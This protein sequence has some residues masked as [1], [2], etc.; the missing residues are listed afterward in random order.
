MSLQQNGGVLAD[1]Q[2]KVHDNL[3]AAGDVCSFVDPVLKRR[4]RCTHWQ[5]A[6]ITGRIAG[7]NMTNGQKTYTHQV[8]RSE[9][10]TILLLLGNCRG[11]S[12]QCLV[13]SV[14][15]AVWAMLTRV[16]STQ[17]QF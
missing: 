8:E 9:M 4:R 1:S 2:L 3:W 6:Q 12:S 14:T 17:Q 15:S 11:R 16:D 10:G 7:E 13:P 5:H